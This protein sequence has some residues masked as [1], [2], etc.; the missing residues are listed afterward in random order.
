M[1]NKV[2]KKSRIN[3]L[4]LEIKVHKA[5]IMQLVAILVS[6]KIKMPDDLLQKITILYGGKHGTEEESNKEN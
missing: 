6:N 1:V 2:R 3:Y 5:I 4:K